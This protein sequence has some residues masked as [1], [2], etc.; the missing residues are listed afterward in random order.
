M[1][2]IGNGE[3]DSPMNSPTKIQRITAYN[4]V[5]SQTHLA[6]K[7]PEE[8]EKLKYI[9][10]HFQDC[11]KIHEI[12]PQCTH[13]YDHI[14]QQLISLANTEQQHKVYTSE[15]DASLFTSDTS[16]QCAFNIAPINT[17]IKIDKQIDE[18]PENNT[19]IHFHSKHKHRDTFGDAHT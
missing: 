11:E 17:D 2:Y 13:T 1:V 15:V 18:I 16:T 7:L 6:T 12:D 19:G 4:A 3:H 9:Y 8:I 10:Q 5:Y 14:L